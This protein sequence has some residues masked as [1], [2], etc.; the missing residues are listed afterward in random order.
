MKRSKREVE[1]VQSVFH[2]GIGAL[3]LALGL[4]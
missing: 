1:R 4:L 3:G 2:V